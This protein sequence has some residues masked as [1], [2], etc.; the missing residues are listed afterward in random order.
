MRNSRS[1]EKDLRKRVYAFIDLNMDAE[2]KIIAYPFMM[3]WHSKSTIYDIIKRKENTIQAERKVE[4]G[5]PAKK[6]NKMVV[7]RLTGRLNHK[8]GIS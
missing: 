2:K 6:I 5:R 4:C 3:E 7:N 1:K 8:D